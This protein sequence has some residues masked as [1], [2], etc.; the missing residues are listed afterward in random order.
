MF[1]GDDHRGSD[2]ARDIQNKIIRIE[3]IVV[4]GLQ[5]RLSQLFERIIK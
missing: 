1:F 5:I 2:I 3:K 4:G